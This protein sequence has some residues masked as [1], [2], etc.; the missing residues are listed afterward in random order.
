[1]PGPQVRS[2]IAQARPMRGLARSRRAQLNAA[3]SSRPK[4]RHRRSCRAP[5]PRRS[6]AGCRAAAASSSPR[7]KASARSRR[8][9]ADWPSCRAPPWSRR[10]ASC[11]RVQKSIST[12][13]VEIAGS[14][15][16]S[17]LR[18]IALTA[19]SL[20]QASVNCSSPALPSTR[21][22]GRGVLQA[23]LRFAAGGDLGPVGALQ[24]QG[25]AAHR[26]ALRR[27]RRDCWRRQSSAQSSRGWITKPAG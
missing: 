19:G 3:R 4:S 11:R 25:I 2:I 8:P 15:A 1:M 13:I 24:Q 20:T 26:H 18:R 16:T 22:R 6:A 23:H 12:A 21:R 10:C 17:I 7:P 5:T 27:R 9:S 14:P